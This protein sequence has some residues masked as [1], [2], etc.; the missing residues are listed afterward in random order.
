MSFE[1]FILVVKFFVQYKINLFLRSSSDRVTIHRNLV[2]ALGIAQT[3]FVVG[4]NA[5]K[6]QVIQLSGFDVLTRLKSISSF[7]YHSLY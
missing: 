2:A 4:I 5:T 1:N 7:I 6:N 3:I